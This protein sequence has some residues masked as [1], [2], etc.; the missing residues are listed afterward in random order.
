MCPSLQLQKPAVV[1]LFRMLD[2]TGSGVIELPQTKALFTLACRGHTRDKLAGVFE[3]FD[4]DCDGLLRQNDVVRMLKMHS[5][6]TVDLDRLVGD[7]FAHSLQLTLD[8]FLRGMVRLLHNSCIIWHTLSTQFQT[9]HAHCLLIQD[10]VCT[11]SP[12]NG[13]ACSQSTEWS[14]LL[15]VHRSRAPRILSPQI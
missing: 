12:Q 14:R 10:P 7:M 6:R 4:T 9:P 5:N 11:L 8:Q 2:L 15:S 3:A 13:H 1:A